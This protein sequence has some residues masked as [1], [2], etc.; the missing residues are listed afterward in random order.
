MYQDPKPKGC[1]IK[2]LT[3]D[4]DFLLSKLKEKEDEIAQLT[5]EIEALNVALFEPRE[6]KGLNTHKLS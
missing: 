1:K 5:E 4:L 3:S 2:V 6:Y